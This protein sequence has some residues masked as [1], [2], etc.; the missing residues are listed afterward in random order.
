LAADANKVR[1]ASSAAR[2]TRGREVSR[3]GRQA[4][5][6]N[7]QA[8]SSCQRAALAPRAQRTTSPAGF[9]ITS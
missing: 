2:S 9:S 5:R 6:S 4:S 7:I 1:S 3:I 8:G